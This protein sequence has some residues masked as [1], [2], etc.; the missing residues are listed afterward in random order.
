[1]F[2]S[3]IALISLAG[4]WLLV[5]MIPGPN[6]VVVTQ[7]AVSA[8]RKAGFLVAL[9]VSS[10]A[11]VWAAASLLGVSA[12]FAYAPWLYDAIR[13][14]GGLYLVFLGLKI[15]RTAWSAISSASG[16]LI[17]AGNSV[18]AFQRG[19]L[20]SFSNPKTAAFF[21]SLFVTAFP[22]HAPGW[23]YLMTVGMVF[24]VS[25]LWYSVVACFFSLSVVQRVYRRAKRGL[26]LFTGALLSV[27][28]IRLAFGRS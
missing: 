12:L 19:I 16:D 4:I 20:T 13:V 28:G 14:I 10:G 21:G 25:L 23:M 11:G 15:V 9:G 6:F 18:P 17:S 22:A 1:M 5:V 24:C 3:C 2:E 7:Y 8:S 27:L 26:D